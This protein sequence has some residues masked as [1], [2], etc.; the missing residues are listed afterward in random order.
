MSRKELKIECKSL[1]E[2]IKA[3]KVE[4]KKYQKENGGCDGG[5]YMSLYR[6]RYEYR[7]KHIA[8]SQ[9]RGRK[10]EEI[11][12]TRKLSICNDPDFTYIK[13]IMDAN[14][15]IPQDVRACA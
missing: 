5:I 3:T 1:A 7:H 2:K 4:L 14:R 13:E 11:E 9:L 10:Y 8:Y 12:S 6:L 15:E